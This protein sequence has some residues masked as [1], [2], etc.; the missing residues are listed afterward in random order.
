MVADIIHQPSSQARMPRVA[1]ASVY[2]RMES[3]VRRGIAPREWLIM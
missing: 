1:Q 3:A 2:S